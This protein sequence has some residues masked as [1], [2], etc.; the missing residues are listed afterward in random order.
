[1]PEMEFDEMKERSKVID[2]MARDLWV[3]ME[4]K[5]QDI[6]KNFSSTM[7]LNHFL[8]TFSNYAAIQISLEMGTRDITSTPNCEK[9]RVS[10]D[11]N[12]LVS[13]IRAASAL[14]RLNP[15]KNRVELCREIISKI[16][17]D[18]DWSFLK[19][20]EKLF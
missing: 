4:N 5:L 9:D 2:N 8:A 11:R 17:M 3:E 10:V 16:E 1:M 18:V 15:E 12:L 14:C 20:N 6:G 13:L 7:E 19:Q